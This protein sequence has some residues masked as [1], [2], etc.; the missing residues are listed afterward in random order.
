MSKVI[1][2]NYPSDPET[3][4]PPPKKVQYPIEAPNKANEGRPSTRLQ[5]IVAPRLVVQ[6]PED[7]RGFVRPC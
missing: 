2:K 3:N 6:T 7:V 4:Y 5:T 1:H